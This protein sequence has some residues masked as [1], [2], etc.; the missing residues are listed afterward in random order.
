METRRRGRPPV[1][2]PQEILD[3]LGKVPDATL[4]R[5]AGVAPQTVTK[6]R[7]SRENRVEITLDQL[8]SEAIRAAKPTPAGMV[9]SYEHYAKIA[10]RMLG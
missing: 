8:V 2:L 10:A 9:I 6:A 1:I 4:A 7:L 3:Q 5:K